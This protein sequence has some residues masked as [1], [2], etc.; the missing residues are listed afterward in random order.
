MAIVLL[1]HFSGAGQQFYVKGEVQDEKGEL[2]RKRTI[3]ILGKDLSTT[4][5]SFSHETPLSN[6]RAIVTLANSGGL[7]A[8]EVEVLWSKRLSKG[9]YE[10]GCQFVRKLRKP[11]A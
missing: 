9:R 8:L 11:G 10:T 6:K 5:L 7:S 3:T 4:G 1:L 2:L